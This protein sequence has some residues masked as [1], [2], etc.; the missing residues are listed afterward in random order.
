[1][2]LDLLALLLATGDKS[3]VAVTMLT[4]KAPLKFFYC[5]NK[6]CTNDEKMYV[7]KLFEYACQ[8]KRDAAD[9]RMDL[10]AAVVNKCEKM[11]RAR[12]SKAVFLTGQIDRRAIYR[13]VVR[14]DA[15]KLFESRPWHIPARPP[16]YVTGLTG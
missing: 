12:L 9:H 2:L 15:A 3:D 16:S 4:T 5:K 1:M 11:I 13:S 7:R 8:T 6:P 14:S 10:L